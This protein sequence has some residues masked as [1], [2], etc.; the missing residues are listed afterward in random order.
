MLTTIRDKIKLKVILDI[1]T[2]RRN[3][4]VSCEFG[5]RGD[6]AVLSVMTELVR[7]CNETRD[8]L[9]ENVLKGY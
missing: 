9:K 2:A 4:E 5:K 1:S 7:F 3:Y 8:S 6:E